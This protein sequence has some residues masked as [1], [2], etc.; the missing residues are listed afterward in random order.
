[1]LALLYLAVV[2]AHSA[3]GRLQVCSAAISIFWCW[4]PFVYCCVLFIFFV[5]CLVVQ[6]F[7]CSRQCACYN[8]MKKS[9]CPLFLWK[10]QDRH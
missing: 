3:P 8:S 7:S 9:R 6:C 2:N 1:V 10:M 4:F 5:D